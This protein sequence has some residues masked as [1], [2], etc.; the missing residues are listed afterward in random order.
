MELKLFVASLKLNDILHNIF[1]KSLNCV[2]NSS[3]NA[4]RDSSHVGM[5]SIMDASISVN[6]LCGSSDSDFNL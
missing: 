6:A 4:K 1:D 5:Y 3:S 2:H